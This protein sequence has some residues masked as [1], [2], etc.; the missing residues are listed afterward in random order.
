MKTLKTHPKSALLAA[1]LL[2][3][4][5]GCER[6]VRLA[7]H[8]LR[9]PVLKTVTHYGKTLDEKASPADVTYVLLR[10][11]RDDFLASTDEERQRALDVL[12]DICAANELEAQQRTSLARD[13]YLYEVV[14]RWTPTVAHY[15]G[16]FETDWDKAAARLETTNRRPAKG[17]TPDVEAVT[18]LMAVADPSGHPNAGVVLKVTLVTDKG[19]WR[20]LNVGFDSARR[21]LT[22][23]GRHIHDHAHGPDEDH[24]PTPNTNGKPGAADKPATP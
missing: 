15:V 4:A 14:Y 20:V 16:D 8:K 2:V 5:G 10:A 6:N 1:A 13:E 7:D 3:V 17:S 9:H 11:M 22:P 19:Y 24:A 21:S 12:F 23:G 18:V